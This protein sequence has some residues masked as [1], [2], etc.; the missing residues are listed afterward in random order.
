MPLKLIVGVTRKVGLPDYCSIG[1][2]CHLELELDSRLLESDLDGFHAQVRGAYIA[3]Q[4]AVSD[5][6]ARLQAQAIA[7]AA[8]L[9]PHANGRAHDREL[10]GGPAGHPARGR[11]SN[12]PATANQVKAIAAIARRQR[13]DLEG[14]LRGG[15]AVT[16]A[17]EL[18]L[19]EASRLIDAPKAA[20]E[21]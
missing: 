18:T 17:E 5:E 6:L 1:A 14:L 7:P 11:R 19:A 3:A 2:S 15:Y 8:P 21:G 13:I 9:P 16:R 4:Q 20:G 12:Q 10:A